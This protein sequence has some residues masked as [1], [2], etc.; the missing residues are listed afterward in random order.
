MIFKKIREWLSNHISWVLSISAV[1]L[2][3]AFAISMSQFNILQNIESRALSELQ[4]TVG[5]Q[6][7]AFSD[8]M[9]EQFQGVRLVAD[10]LAD[11]RHFTSE[12]IKPTLSSIVRTF[13]LCTLCL[14]DM[15]GNTTDYQGN[16]L[17]N[18]SDRE[19]FT[20]IVDGS[21]TQICEYLAETKSTNKPRV[22]LSVPAYDEN[23]EM[24]GVL[25]CSKEI[26]IL[27][28]SLF[29]H[30]AIFDT[31]A[32][33]FICDAAGQVIAANENGYNY[34][35]KHNLSED[36]K[37]NI[38]DLSDSMQYIR[39]TGKAQRINVNNNRYF[40]SYTTVDDCGWGLY[41]LMD[42]ADAVE[43]Y[44]DNKKRIEDTISAMYVHNFAVVD[45]SAI[46]L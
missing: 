13:G 42:E 23:G 17:G 1:L 43:N 9:N 24:L 15:D 41:C 11:G 21:H 45:I 33:I 35:K 25:F 36:T 26:A 10:M 27:E 12:G 14:A 20:E 37:L 44:R 18:C 34:F 19:Y 3:I 38:N 32:G 40:V 16:I 4:S 2:A 46:F 6:A 22:I 30:T 31:K 28:E 7:S 39:K 5:M 29:V 8:H